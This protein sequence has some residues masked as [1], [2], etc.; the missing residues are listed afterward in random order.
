MQ[1]KI[2]KLSPNPAQNK[3]Y[4]SGGATEEVL[5]EITTLEGKPIQSSVVSDH[6]IYI[7][8][9]QVGLYIIKFRTYGGQTI[10]RF[11]KE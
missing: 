4:I 1:P 9:L 7:E 3:L 11:A 5:Y 2:F 10:L 8:N 6:I